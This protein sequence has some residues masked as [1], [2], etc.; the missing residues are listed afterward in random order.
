MDI[1][2]VN[3]RDIYHPQAGGA[4]EVIK[5][6]GRRLVSLGDQVTWFSEEVK[7]RPSVESYEGI[8]LK[9][10]G[11][12][13][14]V[15][16]YSILEARKH[17]I[18]VDSV[19]HAVP[20]FSFTV[21][22][23]TVALIHHIH[24][25][26]VQLELGT[27]S[28]ALVKFMERQVK[29]YDYLIAVSCTTK[30]DLK[31]KL[32]VD[33]SKV[34]VIYNGVDHDK[35]KPGEK[36]REPMILW[37]GRMKSYKNPFDIFEIKKRMKTKAE[38]VVVGSGEMSEKFSTEAE[39]HG[40]KY[41]GRVSEKDK[42][43]LYQRSWAILSTSFIEGWGM[44]IVEGNACGT[45]AVVYRSGSL[46]EVVKD[47]ENGF[48]VNYKD[49]ESAAK[50]LDYLMDESVMKYMSKRSYDSSLKYDWDIT[51]RSY[52]EFLKKISNF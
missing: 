33:E 48:V 28:R 27:F 1:L 30:S 34:K 46:P 35:F 49:Y 51:A 50:A 7:G 25:D 41:L 6:V 40:V 22:R 45:P 11:G 26:V 23:K 47:G 38:I 39:R 2:F 5:E 36:S 8:T 21:N 31:T 52:N 37:I 10:R 13:A 17:E 29:R 32:N 20:F 3:H 16:V 44:T 18:V 4:E 9:R 43:N 12:R 42:V 24:Q 14:S 15:H 19:A